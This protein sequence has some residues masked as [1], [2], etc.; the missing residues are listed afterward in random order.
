MQERVLVVSEQDDWSEAIGICLSLRDC[1]IL[2]VGD[3]WPEA[4][5]RFQPTIAVLNADAPHARVRLQDPRIR[6]GKTARE[7]IALG[8]S[9]SLVIVVS[10]PGNRLPG[11]YEAIPGEIVIDTDADPFHLAEKIL[12]AAARIRAARRAPERK[13]QAAID[14]SLGDGCLECHLSIGNAPWTF[15]PVTWDKREI[16]EID[17]EFCDYEASSEKFKKKVDQ[18][19]L[20]RTAKRLL[21]HAFEEYLIAA[22]TFC[23]SVE[24]GRI[25]RHLYYR[26]TVRDGEFDFVPLELV[27]TANN[28]EYLRSASPLARRVSVPTVHYDPERAAGAR[29]RKGPVNVLFI[30]SNVDGSVSIPPHRFKGLDPFPLRE[31]GHIRTECEQTTELYGRENV[32]VCDL[33]VGANNFQTLTAAFAKGPYDIVHFAGHSVRSDQ[34]GDVFLV[35]PGLA[36]ALPVAYGAE[37]FAAQ[38]SQA[39]ARLVILSSCEGASCRSLSRLA[40]FGIPAV[41]GFRWEIDDEDAGIFTPALHDALRGRELPVMQA[42]QEALRAVKGPAQERLSW[43]SPVLM[44]QTNLWY[45]YRVEGPA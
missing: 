26:F 36:E 30:L 25:G 6:F 16:T 31:L 45:D 13:S 5:E 34:T 17:R 18:D 15:W 8:P 11:A 4:I 2:V 29:G 19:L 33:Q 35:L 28:G 32:Q 12:S 7:L 42:F 40:A 27:A 41:V 14:I 21:W 37:D 22:R 20:Q 10:V 23:D 24:D 9:I 3:G 1:E 44:L 38:A 39:G 43:F